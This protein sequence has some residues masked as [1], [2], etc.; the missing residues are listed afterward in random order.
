MDFD[1]FLQYIV[2]S[3][4]C[5]DPDTGKLH[6]VNSTWPSSTFCGNYH[7]KLRKKNMTEN[8]LEP[9]R[10]INFTNFDKDTD[11]PKI[12]LLL[13]DN[14]YLRKNK[15]INVIGINPAADPKTNLT[16]GKVPSKSGNGDRYL[17]DSEIKTISAI[18]HTVKKSDL[19]AIV[20]IYQ[21]A[22]NIYDEIDKTN[23]EVL[24]QETVNDLNLKIPTTIKGKLLNADETKHVS[25][26]YDP[27]SNNNKPQSLHIVKPN[28]KSNGKVFKTEKLTT[29]KSI[30]P[31]N[32]FGRTISYF[33]GALTTKDFGRLP[34]YYP[35]SL[36]QRASSYI[37]QPL[38]VSNTPYVSTTDRNKITRTTQAPAAKYNRGQKPAIYLPYPF[39]NVPHNYN[40]TSPKTLY[41]SK[42]YVDRY[43]MSL[44]KAKEQSKNV[45]LINPDLENI[46][47]LG[48]KREKLGRSISK[49]MTPDK[50]KEQKT[51]H[52]W[53]T[54]PISR[55]ILD[56]V[57]AHLDKTRFLKPLSLRK[58][59][60]LEKVG[61]VVKLDESNKRNKRSSKV[62]DEA[63]DLEFYEVYLDKTTCKSDYS[64]PGFFRYGNLSQ[65]FPQCCPQRIKD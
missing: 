24:I 46:Q 5:R 64:I 1:Q 11:I 18:L 39:F 9:V 12:E 51:T 25:Y 61:R 16:P 23:P 60:K 58:K 59:I 3:F 21:L 55:T 38:V 7:C 42:N 48:V 65:P 41:H 29:V 40:L 44:D 57:R 62:K 50:S 4:L 20:E 8:D 45:V 43:E 35:L 49:I 37:H 52:D 63:A 34:Y 53:Q 56:E 15:N 32:D 30:N 19:E 26:W 36:F 17:T 14:D 47:E 10:Q 13:N 54:D 22:Q 33:D 2:I 31:P 6:T 27:I 28:S